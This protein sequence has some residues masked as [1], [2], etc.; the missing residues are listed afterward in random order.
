MASRLFRI[1]VSGV[2][3]FPLD[4]LRYDG[5]Y[6]ETGADVSALDRSLSAGFEPS[7]VKLL[8]LDDNKKWV[9]TEGRWQSF[10]WKVI[11]TEVVR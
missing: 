7:E 6:P 9:P 1:T 8:H 5:C 10:L 11:K 3:R 4:M 2:G